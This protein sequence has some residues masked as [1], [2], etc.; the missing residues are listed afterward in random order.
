MA[1]G[2]VCQSPA[3]QTGEEREEVI[4]IQIQFAAW[5]AL[6]GQYEL[7]LHISG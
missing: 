5:M 2:K 3:G 6:T 4:D 1:A 7:W